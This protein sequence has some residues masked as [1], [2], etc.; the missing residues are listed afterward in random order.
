MVPAARAMAVLVPCGVAGRTCLRPGGGGTALGVGGSPVRNWLP[1][2]TR[3]TPGPVLS[4]TAA[5]CVAYSGCVLCYRSSEAARRLVIYLDRAIVLWPPF[6]GLLPSKQPPSEIKC[7]KLKQNGDHSCSCFH[8]FRKRR[9]ADRTAC[10]WFSRR[11]TVGGCAAG[12]RARLQ[13]RGPAARSQ[14]PLCSGPQRPGGRAGAPR[15][16]HALQP[17]PLGTP[18]GLP[19]TPGARRRSSAGPAIAQWRAGFH[20]SQKPASSACTP[21]RLPGAGRRVRTLAALRAPPPSPRRKGGGPPA[22]RGPPS[23]GQ[24]RPSASCPRRPLAF[25]LHV[26]KKFHGPRWMMYSFLTPSIRLH[27]APGPGPRPGRAGC[28]PSPVTAAPPQVRAREANRVHRGRAVRRAARHRA[29]RTELADAQG[30][31]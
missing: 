3:Q 11:G 26:F 5:E 4:R 20:T 6:P 13:R 29:P 17:C 27:A 22:A 14:A 28:W 30:G 23:P 2:A 12:S 9:V 19:W 16:P 24:G 10:P 18:R 7:K 1:S 15:R 31:C 21:H 25:S 8:Y